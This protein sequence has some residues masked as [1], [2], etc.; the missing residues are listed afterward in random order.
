[1]LRP[2]AQKLCRCEHIH[3]QNACS[4]SDI[5]SH[6]NRLILFVKHLAVR[7]DK[8]VSNTATIR[9]VTKFHDKSVCYKCPSSVKTPEATAVTIS[10]QCTSCNNGIR[11]QEFHTATGFVI[12]CVLNERA[13]M[14][15][16]TFWNTVP[17]IRVCSLFLL[18][19]RSRLCHYSVGGAWWHLCFYESF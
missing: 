10:K 3:D 14:K 1:M 18:I 5:I 11:L 17:Y 8:D 6:Q 2:L 19:S 16:T 7:P 15:M 9:L 13:R 4:F 12:L